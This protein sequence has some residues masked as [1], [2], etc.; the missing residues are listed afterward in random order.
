MSVPYEKRLLSNTSRLGTGMDPINP[1]DRQGRCLVLLKRRCFHVALLLVVATMCI[2]QPT[3]SQ[4]PYPPQAPIPG[5]TPLPR[6]YSGPQQPRQ[7]QEYAFRPD[8]SNPEY[9]ECLQLEKNWKALWERYAQMYQQTRWIYPGNPQYAQTTY[10]L[11]QLKMQLDG[12]W[13][14]FSSRCIYFPRR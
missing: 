8:L 10:Y 1:H 9:G 2:P 6:P 14:A 5:A 12:A 7:P 11:Q 4:V 13:Y 3:L